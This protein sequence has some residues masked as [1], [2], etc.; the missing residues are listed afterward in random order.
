MQLLLWCRRIHESS[1]FHSRNLSCLLI[2]RRQ[3]DWKFLPDQWWLQLGNPWHCFKALQGKRAPVFQG[4]HFS[5]WQWI[6]SFQRIPTY[7][8]LILKYLPWYLIIQNHFKSKALISIRCQN[9]FKVFLCKISCAPCKPLSAVKIP[10]HAL[11]L[12]CK[13]P[14][15]KVQISFPLRINNNC[16]KTRLGL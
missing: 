15:E 2:R 3:V 16:K 8:F 13:R 1:C 11:P 9:Y 7:H 6:R 14:K 5:L 10:K 12:G 4:S